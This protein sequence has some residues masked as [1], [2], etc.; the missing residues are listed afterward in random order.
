MVAGALDG[1]YRSNDGGNN[2]QKISPAD[3][4]VK[5]I[6]SIAVDPKDPNT[7][8]KL[9]VCYWIKDDC[10]NAWKY[11]DECKKL[12]LLIF[13]D[14]IPRYFFLAFSENKFDQEKDQH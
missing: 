11:Y 7:T 12:G 8:Y 3:G 6:E 5:N 10:D 9:S 13:C 2:W 1:V 14:L 4:I